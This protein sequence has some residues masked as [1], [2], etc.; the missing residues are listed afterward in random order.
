VNV[1]HPSSAEPR[2]HGM[3]FLVVFT[4]LAVSILDVIADRLIGDVLQIE[5]TRGH[6]IQIATMAILTTATLWLT[7]IRPLQNDAEVQRLSAQARQADLEQ[8]GAQTQFE[9]QLHRALEMAATEEMVYRSTAKALTVAVGERDAQLLLAD[10][11][12]AHLKH[13]VSV[14]ESGCGVATPHD[15]PAIRRAQTLQFASSAGL[16]A[17]PYLEGRPGGE[18]GAVCVPLSVGGRSIGVL[19]TVTQPVDPFEPGQVTRLESIATL[20]GARIG[21]LRVMSA[22]TLQ[23]ATDPLTGLLNRRAFEN[24]AHALL[25]QQRSFA[26][27]MGDLDHFKRLNDT[28]GHDAGDRALRLFARVLRASLRTDD[29]ISRYGGEEFVIVFPDDTARSAAAALGRM[30]EALIVALGDATV[31]GFTVSYGVS[32]TSQSTDL[33]E[34]CRIADT[35]LF[36]AKRSG[37]NQVVIA[38]SAGPDVT[39]PAATG[40][41]A[42]AV[43]G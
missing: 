11:S 31:P 32:D 27:A 5:S 10:S 34:L 25:R 20:A 41:E 26:I 21:M 23:A 16:D 22:T 28:H 42:P 9:S 3:I 43:T 39:Q 38:P 40:D 2:R 35:A 29:V 8:H 36:Q 24:K 30:Q 1:L 18:C 19:H 12:D 6:V 7:V 17:C 15:C 13:A 14:G 33:E 37:R 4:A